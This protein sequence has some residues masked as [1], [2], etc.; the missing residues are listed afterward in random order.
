M[1][2]ILTMKSKAG[3]DH[4]QQWLEAVHV[5]MKVRVLQKNKQYL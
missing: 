1:K 3:E 2:G 5:T 4:K